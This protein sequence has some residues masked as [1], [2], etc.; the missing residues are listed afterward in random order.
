M[1][2]VVFGI[3]VQPLLLAPL[4]VSLYVK[5]DGELDEVASN[6]LEA[7][8]G[9]V[10]WVFCCQLF[11]KEVEPTGD[12]K[13]LNLLPTDGMCLSTVTLPEIVPGSSYRAA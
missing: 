7:P 4:N 9:P 1:V 11:E 2:D 5:H 6:P 3:V 13:N 10:M 8:L 12:A